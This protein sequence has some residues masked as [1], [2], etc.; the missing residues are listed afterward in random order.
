MLFVIR[1]DSFISQHQ[2]KI[3]GFK[4][5][6]NYKVRLSVEIIKSINLCLDL[7]NIDKV[8]LDDSKKDF[9]TRESNGVLVELLR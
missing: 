6:N 1:P 7:I 8:D 4:I 3:F 2:E 9:N 5:K